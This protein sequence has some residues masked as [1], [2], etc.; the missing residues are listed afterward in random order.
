MRPTH[1]G[2]GRQG[3]TQTWANTLPRWLLNVSRRQR[4]TLFNWDALSL[5]TCTEHLIMRRLIHMREGTL[6]HTHPG[7]NQLKRLE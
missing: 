1:S 5:H 6:V 2:T 7:V 3:A 4:L